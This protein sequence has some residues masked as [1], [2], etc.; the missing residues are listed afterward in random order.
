LPFRFSNG[1]G[2]VAG[3]SV[4]VGLAPAV[5]GV[6]AGLPFPRPLSNGVVGAVGAGEAMPAGDAGDVPKAPGRPGRFPLSGPITGAVGAG[7]V[8]PAGGII[9]EIPP[10]AC[11]APAAPVGGGMFG[12]SVLI[13]SLDRKS[14]R[15][16]SSHRTISYAV[17]C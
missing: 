13:F 14:T 17:F 3:A 11:P 2:E 4:A 6:P 10:G 15:L 9:G 8:M 5:G 1:A 12:F 16:N 7:E